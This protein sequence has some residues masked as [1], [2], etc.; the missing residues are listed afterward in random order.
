MAAEPDDDLEDHRKAQEA[1]QPGCDQPTTTGGQV[2][3]APHGTQQPPAQPGADQEHQ[4]PGIG[5]Q[6]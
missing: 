4:R 5:Q 2:A 6:R 3:A 1:D